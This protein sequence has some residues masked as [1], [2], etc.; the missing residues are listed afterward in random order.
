MKQSH[1]INFVMMR[2]DQRQLCSDVREYRSAC[3]W[4][5]HHMLKGKIQLQLPRKKNRCKTKLITM[6]K[7]L[8][9]EDS[10]PVQLAAG[11]I[12]S[13]E[14]FTY[15][16]SNISRDGKVK[17]EVVTRLGKAS[18]AFGCLK[19]VVFQTVSSVQTSKENF[20]VQWYFLPCSMVQKPEQ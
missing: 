8:R 10:L 13:V 3:C 12:A 17:S 2:R 18:R 19:S 11:E 1:I 16:G 9:H 5:D 6:G 14:E 4:T 15:L 20:I 7:Q